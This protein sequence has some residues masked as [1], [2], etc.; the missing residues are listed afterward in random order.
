MQ[1]IRNRALAANHWRLELEPPR[2]LETRDIPAGDII[3]CLDRWIGDWQQLLARGTRIAVRLEAGAD[4]ESLLATQFH[5]LW[6]I[7][8]VFDSFAEG[9]G[10][11]QARL[12]RE[13][14]DF[15]G[16]LRASGDVSRDRIAFLERCGVNE[17]VLNPDT[18]PS[19][20]L[21]A[22]TEISLQYQPA[23]VG[24]PVVAGL[25]GYRPAA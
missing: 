12:L 7:E 15:L 5:E 11:S 4:L 10:Y 20:A 9:R 13:R 23:V 19:Q 2:Q 3:V 21:E 18:D 24:N 1:I 25:R 14:H 8:L 22:F 6:M 16:D 17:F